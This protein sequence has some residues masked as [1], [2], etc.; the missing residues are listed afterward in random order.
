[1]AMLNNQRVTMNLL[2]FG[3]LTSQI[4]QHL[5]TKHQI[6][7]TA[8]QPLSNG[9]DPLRSIQQIQQTQIWKLGISWD[10]LPFYHGLLPWFNN[11][12]YGDSPWG[13][14]HEIMD[15][16]TRLGKAPPDPVEVDWNGNIWKVHIN[17]N[18]HYHNNNNNNTIYIYIFYK[19]LI[20]II[21]SELY[22]Q[23]GS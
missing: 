14:H 8:I 17:N 4:Y 15:E 16:I 13:T 20:R 12:I 23:N 7:S 1:M 18:N 3:D 11:E 9:W 19:V 2:N 21:I 6:W 10:F 5:R 22:Y